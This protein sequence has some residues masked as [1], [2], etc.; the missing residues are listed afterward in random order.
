MGGDAA[1]PDSR[2]PDAGMPMDATVETY[3]LDV[4]VM[5]EGKVVARV[6]DL[7]PVVIDCGRGAST[8]Q[9]DAD[10]EASVTLLARGSSTSSLASWGGDCAGTG[11]DETCVLTMDGPRTVSATFVPQ[12]RTVTVLR[13]HY[14]MCGGR[15]FSVPAGIDCTRDASAPCASSFAIGTEVTLTAT[16]AAGTHFAQFEEACAGT[17]GS[18]C[19][20]AVPSESVN[21]AARF[22]SPLQVAV[23]GGGQVR[24]TWTASSTVSATCDSS[25]LSCI[26]DVDCQQSVTLEAVAGPGELFLGWS[27]DCSGSAPSCSVLMDQARSVTA[28][29]VRAYPVEVRVDGPGTVSLPPGFVC[30]GTVCRSTIQSGTPLQIDARPNVGAAFMD[31]AGACTGTDSAC[32]LVVSGPTSVTA[33]FGYAVDVSWSQGGRI[34]EGGILSCTGRSCA[35]VVAPGTRVTFTALADPGVSL[36]GFASPCA[37]SPCTVTV[38]R[39]L[40][41]SA[42]FGF[43]VRIDLAGAGAGVTSNITLRCAFGRCDGTIPYGDRLTVTSQPTDINAALYQFSGDCQGAACDFVPSGAV[44][45]TASFGVRVTFVVQGPGTITSTP[46][47]VLGPPTSG[48]G[49]RRCDVGVPSGGDL[50]YR[51]VPDAGAG[52]EDP[53]DE[54]CATQTCVERVT[55]PSQ[56][57]VDFGWLVRVTKPVGIRVASSLFGCELDETSCVNTYPVGWRLNYTVTSTRTFWRVDAWGG[58]A[59]ACNVFPMNRCSAPPLTGSLHVDV[60]ASFIP[61]RIQ[62]TQ[63]GDFQPVVVYWVHGGDYTTHEFLCTAAQCETYLLSELDRFRLWYN[64]PGRS[65]PSWSSTPFN[66][67]SS[68]TATPFGTGYRVEHPGVITSNASVTL[69]WPPIP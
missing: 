15:I 57:S 21:V 7:D 39:A 47:C 26:E 50:R 14:P 60:A 41:V 42:Q 16:A 35:G 56:K 37:A 25:Q 65:T 43:P 3:R 34:D 61:R 6:D 54:A 55:S 8:C 53:G 2:L 62:I 1:T 33:R 9:F 4:H 29:F 51:F 22:T 44:R 17:S 20:L 59:G 5:G 45:I 13:G 19:R 68:P 11:R 31:Y 18:V 36:L 30:S 38:D 67:I 52:V 49:Q 24:S 28:D 58:D 32:R 69:G 23:Q 12:A 27:G 10:K 40:R 64:T 48:S 46:A 66:T 63:T